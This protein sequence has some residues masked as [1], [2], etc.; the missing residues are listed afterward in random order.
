MQP[1]REPLLEAEDRGKNYIDFFRCRSYHRTGPESYYER[2]TFFK[3][4][5]YKVLTR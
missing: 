2:S 5:F 4:I 3:Q 1:R